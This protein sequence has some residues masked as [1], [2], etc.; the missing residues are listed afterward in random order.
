MPERNAYCRLDG[1]GDVEEVVRIH[2]PH[3][4]RVVTMKREDL[5]LLLLMLKSSYVLLFDS[6]RFDPGN[7]TGWDD[8]S[9]KHASSGRMRTSITVVAPTRVVKAICVD[10]R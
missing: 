4:G 7:F 1:N 8:G 3:N 2:K 10:S 6:K 9:K 5:D